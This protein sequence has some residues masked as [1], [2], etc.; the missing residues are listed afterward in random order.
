MSLDP[1]VL[2]FRNLKNARYLFPD[3]FYFIKHSRKICSAFGGHLISIN[4]FVNFPCT[5]MGG[6]LFLLLNSERVLTPII[7]IIIFCDYFHKTKI[8]TYLISCHGL[9][10]SGVELN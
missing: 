2:N 5:K 9:G 3:N 7:G 8:S 10:K 4:L 6:I 1:H